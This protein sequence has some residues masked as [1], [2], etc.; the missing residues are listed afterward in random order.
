MKICLPLGKSLK[1]AVYDLK[2]IYGGYG[3]FDNMNYFFSHNGYQIVD[4]SDLS[5]EEIT[6]KNAW[7]VCDQDL[8]NRTLKECDQSFASGKPFLNHVM[9]T[10]NHRPFTYS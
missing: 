9:T 10:S 7:G 1:N 2:F 8:F 5:K 4:H 3:Y 6:F